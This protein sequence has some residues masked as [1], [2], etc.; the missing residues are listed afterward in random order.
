MRRFFVFCAT[1]GL[2]LANPGQVAKLLT[3]PCGEVRLAADLQPVQAEM[4]K[5]LKS[6]RHYLVL[7]SG[8]VTPALP[9]TVDKSL[10]PGHFEITLGR[11]SA[12][13]GDLR[14]DCILVVAKAQVLAKFP[15]A[16]T[17]DPAYGLPAK[18]LPS[19]QKVAATQ[20]GALVLDPVSVW[21]TVLTEGLRDHDQDLLISD[22]LDLLLENAPS[23]LSNR[24]VVDASVRAKLLQVC[25][26]LLAE[27][28][29]LRDMEA[30]C[31]AFIAGGDVDQCT[32]RARQALRASIC[33]DLAD[34]KR[35]ISVVM[36]A[37][38]AD[39]RAVKKAVDRLQKKGKVPVLCTSAAARLA[40]RKLAAKDFPHTTILSEEERAP[41]FHFVL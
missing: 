41:G 23:A 22:H 25:R 7:E 37:P 34:E 16:Q 40:L 24:I 3:T 15:E 9:F 19:S 21:A 30:I 39:L 28:V 33:R 2:A 38:G 11:Q 26:N 1:A 27:G 8:F 17:T 29:G 4:E 32:E 36:M 18:W 6:I 35:N 13:K 5:R 31:E 20:A 12:G 10:A 14:R